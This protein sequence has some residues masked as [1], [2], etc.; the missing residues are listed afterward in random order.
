MNF[1]LP[2]KKKNQ[3]GRHECAH[4]RKVISAYCVSFS[5]VIKGRIC[6]VW[7]VYLKAVN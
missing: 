7:Y 3:E 4:F 1:S 2:Q 6:K 5:T